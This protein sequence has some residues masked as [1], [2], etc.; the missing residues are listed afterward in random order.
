M[1]PPPRSIT[2]TASRC[3]IM[4]CAVATLLGCSAPKPGP[5]PLLTGSALT[6]SGVDPSKAPFRNWELVDRAVAAGTIEHLVVATPVEA[7]DHRY[8]TY[9]LLGP[10]DQPGEL[11]VERTA[12]GLTLTVRLGRFGLPELEAA[13]LGSVRDALSAPPED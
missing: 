7:I 3:G 2:Q 13:V 10:H 8:R 6:A 1:T 5:R 12:S 9:T 4:I 11:L